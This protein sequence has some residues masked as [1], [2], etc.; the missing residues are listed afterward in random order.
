MLQAVFSGVGQLQ[1]RDVPMPEPAADEVLVRVEASGVCGTD[2][3]FFAGH[4]SVEPP[5][6]LG[7]EYAGTVV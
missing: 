6:V 5:V 4:R 2:R 3:S 1:V 7:H